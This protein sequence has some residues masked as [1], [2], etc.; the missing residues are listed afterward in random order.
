MHGIT[1]ENNENL[2]QDNLQIEIWA[3]DLLNMKF[4]C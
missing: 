2:S 1:E 3:W 4:E